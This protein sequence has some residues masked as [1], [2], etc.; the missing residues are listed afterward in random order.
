MIKRKTQN[1]S[2][3]PEADIGEILKL[4]DGSL[5]NK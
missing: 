4:F 2:L 3:R 5:E 1:L